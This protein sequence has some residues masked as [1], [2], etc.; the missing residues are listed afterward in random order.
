MGIFESKDQKEMA[1]Q[2]AKDM[3]I[4]RSDYEIAMLKQQANMAQNA[5]SSQYSA[6][7]S[8]SMAQTKQAMAQS[9]QGADRNRIDPNK[10]EAFQIPLSQLVTMWQVRFGDEWLDDDQKLDDPF[11]RHAKHRLDHNGLFERFDGYLRLKENVEKIL[12]NR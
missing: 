5:L 1:H 3:A 10:S 9:I 8:N 12:A 11:Y 4:V 2:Y 7:L 6:A